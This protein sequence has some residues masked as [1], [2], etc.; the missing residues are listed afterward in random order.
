MAIG[1]NRTA[2]LFASNGITSDAQREIYRLAIEGCFIVCVTVDDL[3][4]M[5][6]AKECKILILDKWN[7]LQENVELT[8]IL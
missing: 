1:S 6:S 8:T 2:I 3:L 4:Q 5:T 7:L